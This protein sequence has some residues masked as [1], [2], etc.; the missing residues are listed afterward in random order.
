M[1]PSTQTDL[2]YWVTLLSACA[3]GETAADF[4]SH[5]PMELGYAR[6]SLILC[7]LVFIAL[8]VERAARMPNPLRYWTTVV[9]MATAGTTIADWLSR[10]MQLGYLYSSAILTV[11]FIAALVVWA[12]CASTPAPS[13]R[14][15]VLPHI[16]IEA[17]MQLLPQTDFRYWTVIMVASTL[18][19]TLGDYFAD[20]LELGF[21]ASSLILLALL[22]LTLFFEFRTGASNE[23][24]YW[25]ALIL[26]STIGAT[27]G[28]F[29]TKEDGLDLGYFWGNGVLIAAFLVIALVRMVLAGG[30]THPE[31][32]DGA[33]LPHVELR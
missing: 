28:D 5:G 10:S 20:G 27:S 9:V 29:L 32:T 33:L 23:K 24:R 4:L 18:G 13:A 16:E 19:T 22:A 11:C 15:G 12:K 30:R 6:A 25:T 3:M 14:S 7:S 31:A 21:G 17:P 26:C 1:R 8:A 2:I